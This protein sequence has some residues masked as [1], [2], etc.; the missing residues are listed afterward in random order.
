MQPTQA[1][2]AAYL[3]EDIGSG[4]LTANIIPEQTT[5]SLWLC[6]SSFK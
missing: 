1:E 3:A 6:A 4:D 2:I 5:A